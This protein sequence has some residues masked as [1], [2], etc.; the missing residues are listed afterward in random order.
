EAPEF[1]NADFVEVAKDIAV[2]QHV[3][4][5]KVI[6][7]YPEMEDLLRLAAEKA[8]KQ[9][10][11]AYPQINWLA[12]AGRWLANLYL[13]TSRSAFRTYLHDPS[14]VNR[15]MTECGFQLK[16]IKKRFPWRVEV[17]HRV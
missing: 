14:E 2:H 3:T 5:D 13:R 10:G 15:V 8:E 1:I 17:W 12:R 6:C 9:V 16:D 4:L 7:C 11:L